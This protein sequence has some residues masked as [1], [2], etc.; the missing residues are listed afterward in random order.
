VDSGAALI[1]LLIVLPALT[2]ALVGCGGERKTEM[3]IEVV[4][5]WGK[6]HYR[7]TCDPPGGDVPRPRELCALLAEEAGVMLRNDEERSTCAGGMSTVHLRARGVF[8]ARSVD[9]TDID[10]CQGNLEAQ[11]LWLS[12]LPTPP[13]WKE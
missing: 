4:N 9:A 2:V 1:R 6:Q 12:Q 7:L 13:G 8:D 11:R 3:T 10:A 5:A